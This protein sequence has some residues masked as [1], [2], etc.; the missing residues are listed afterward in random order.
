MRQIAFYD[1]GDTAFPNAQ[2]RVEAAS[3]DLAKDGIETLPSQLYR[4][5]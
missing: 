3:N 4:V 1:T 2:H 5:D